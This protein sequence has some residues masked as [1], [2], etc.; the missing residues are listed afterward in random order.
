MAGGNLSILSEVALSA[1]HGYAQGN[2][3][4][5]DNLMTNALIIGGQTG[6]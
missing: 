2:V 5:I 1:V 4:M 3:R 6:K